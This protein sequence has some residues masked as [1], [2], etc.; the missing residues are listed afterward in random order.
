MRPSVTIVI[1]TTGR[2][3]LERLLESIAADRG[4]WDGAVIAVDD[5]RR[6]PAPV[7]RRPWVTVV[8]GPARGPAAARN[9]GWR[10]AATEWVAFLDDDVVLPRGW[11]GDLFADLSEAG[12]AA[13]TQGFVRVPLPDD[14]RPTDWERN[15]AG[16][17]TAPYATA[18]I[19]YRRAALAAVGGFD[20]R[21]RRAYREDS[22]LAVR[23][24][25]TGARIERG[26]RHALHPVGPARWTKS[27]TAQ[28]GN[29]DDVRM[30]ALH[31]RRWRMLAQAPAGR[32]RRHAAVTAAAVLAAAAT[33]LRRR[34]LGA[35]AAAGWLIGTAELAWAR[36]SPGP[37]TRSEVAAMLATSAAIPPAA[38]AQRLRGV[39]ESRRITPWS[40]P[41]EA[42]LFD[43]DG[44]LVVDVPYN[45][46][47]DRVLPVE[48]ARAALDRVRQ[49]GIPT[50]VVTNQ[51]GVPRG[52][53]TPEQVEAVNARI[54]AVLGPMGPWMVCMHPLD[55]EC[56]C[57]KPAPGL[58]LRA[59]AALGV[60]P[61]RC[62]VI[63]DTGMDMEAAA[64]A[65]A[66]GVLVPSPVTRQEEIDAAATV[67]GDL[68]SAVAILLGGRS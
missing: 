67:A 27:V 52:L 16:L 23:L 68:D 66:R 49:A 5:R 41:P 15:V 10:A 21:F 7:T 24:L 42:V 22:D 62:A 14:R 12:D 26:R 64:A 60:D 9:A 47:P 31:G 29:A 44:T 46:D 1:P 54:D 50:A 2:P 55:V 51:S 20:E 18:D 13:G 25:R 33:L 53:I 36:I 56:G 57:R 28:S 40:G 38:T 39:V 30:A 32:H 8:P 48:T 45:G 58:V 43:R 6:R 4:D 59:A 35:A 19:A 61:A 63:G 11:F 17:E 3:S 65:G 34:R 37:R